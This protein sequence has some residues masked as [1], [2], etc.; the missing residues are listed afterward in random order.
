MA[1]PLTV[2]SS[3]PTG[4]VEVFAFRD[5]TAYLRLCVFR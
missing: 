2:M 5:D 4:G 3:R 1:S